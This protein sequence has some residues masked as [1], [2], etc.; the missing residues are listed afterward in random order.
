MKTIGTS[1]V[2]TDVQD[3]VTDAIARAVAIMGLGA[4]ALIHLLDAPSKFDE[5]PY[6]GW[7]YLGLIA[8]CI[9]LAV[10]LLRSSDLR[11]WA[12]TAALPVAVLIGFTL[13]RTTGLPQANGDIG[14]WTESLGL[15]S[16]FVEGSLVALA[17][18]VV[19]TRRTHTVGVG[20]RIAVTSERARV[21]A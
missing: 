15:A 11:V 9:A 7:M 5:T 16:L 2:A 10:G 21:R 6:M 3:V 19:A 12:A 18:A 14:N 4:I 17:G 13:T 1:R 8:S 20:S